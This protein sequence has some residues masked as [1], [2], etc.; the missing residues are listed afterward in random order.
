MPIFYRHSVCSIISFVDIDIEIMRKRLLVMIFLDFKTHF[1]AKVQL[2]I[3]N[4]CLNRIVSIRGELFQQRRISFVP[5]VT[6][7]V[8]KNL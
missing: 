5:R 3:S 6:I 4:Q 1:S 7:L 2:Q 8:A